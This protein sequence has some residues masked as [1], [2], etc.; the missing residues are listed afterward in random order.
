MRGGWVERGTVL[1]RLTRPHFAFYRGYLDNVDLRTLASL[2]LE[3]VAESGDEETDLRIVRSS[4]K[5][6]REQLVVA[7]KR[8]QVSRSARLLQIKPESL[9]ISHGNVPTLEEFREERDPHEM[10]SEETLLAFFQ[11]TY[12]S[13]ARQARLAERNDRLRRQQR[14]ALAQLEDLADADP[15]LTDRVDGWLDPMLAT[16]LRDAGIHTLAELIAKI[17][18]HGY[19]WYSKVPR[20]GEKAAAQIV[21]WLTTPAVSDA[22]DVTLHVRAVTKR[23]DLPAV[24]P[25]MNPARTAIV[26]LEEFLTPP[27]L[28]GSD[29]SNRG[30]RCLLRARN[31]HEAVEAWLSLLKPGSHTF[32]SYRREAER[33]LLWCIM[34]KRKP[35]SSMSIEDCRDYRDFLWYL[36]S[37]VEVRL[38]S[39]TLLPSPGEAADPR[40]SATYRKP[41]TV[42]VFETEYWHTRFTLPQ[43]RWIGP[44]GTPRW[45]ELW[46]PFEGRLSP[47][48]QTLALV[49]VKSMMQ[50]LTDQHYLHGNPM[51][52]VKPLTAMAEDLDPSRALTK[53]QWA[54]VKEYLNKLKREN[55]VEPEDRMAI[56]KYVRL[57]FI[58]ALAYS[59]GMRLSEL[60]DLRRMHIESF[61]RLEDGATCWM[62]KIVGKGLKKREVQLNRQ[63]MEELDR[64]F[65]RRGHRCFQEA[66]KD[67]PVIAA[68]PAYRNKSPAP[69][70]M[71]D[72]LTGKRLYKILKRFFAEA[73]DD[74]RETN[75]EM[76]EKV[77]RAST[78]WLR[79]TYATHALEAGMSLEVVRDLL[80]HAS[81][82]TTSIY[83]NAERDRSSKEAEDMGPAL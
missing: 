74:I 3:N 48:S 83:V 80:G 61:V 49:I 78:H 51:K 38:V 34:E 33:F 71:D 50:W 56:D 44:H 21:R 30:E 4:V 43:Q 29:G 23:R 53:T 24:V 45:S 59:T 62:A 5:W 19:R 27:E 42:T 17:H 1:I 16:R 70:S 77:Q 64:Y 67:T 36:G 60:T 26:P 52:A 46:R 58:L 79:H 10:Y 12:G 14:N 32:R 11:E 20:V 35:L 66:P 41:P 2:Y 9:R 76:A 37:T 73:A 63:V 22:L 7:A 65:I 28:D 72:T 69:G 81:I 55:D 13:T 40:A 18:A 47:S 54:A 39:P 15:K 57:R 8:S 75:R 68:L 25:A 6:I 82:D 31:D